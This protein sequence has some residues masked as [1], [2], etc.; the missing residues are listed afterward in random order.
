MSTTKHLNA[1]IAGSLLLTLVSC[2]KDDSK[3]KTRAE[4]N[5]ICSEIDCLSSVNWK[6]Q[7]EGRS[8]PYKSRV[9][10]NG[11]TVLNE[12]VSKQKYSIDR[13]SNPEA[14]YL[15]NYYVPKRGDVKID[16]IDLGSDCDS[17]STFI[18]NDKVDFEVS[19]TSG[20][21]EIIISL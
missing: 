9:D 6:I 16:I 7:L 12:C 14:L 15:D 4:V 13:T 2:G 21:A 11:T 20:F 18:S 1:L 10:I 3:S 17:E 8:F 19:K 5:P